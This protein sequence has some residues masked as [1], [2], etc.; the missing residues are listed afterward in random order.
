[1]TRKL[2]EEF[3][4]RF[5][6]CDGAEIYFAPGRVNLIGDHTD[7]NGGHVFP[8]ALTMGTYAVARKRADRKIRLFSMNFAKTG[9]IE[10]SLEDLV[11]GENGGWSDYPKGVFWAFFQYGYEIPYGMDL[12]LYGN[13]PNGAGLSSSA[14]LEVLVGYILNDF[15]GFR[16][17][18][19]ELAK[20][21]Q[22]AENHYNG[23]NCG[24]MDQFAVA[25]GKKQYGI[26]LNTTTLDYQYV[27]I[28]LDDVRLVI[29]CSNKKRKLTDSKYNERRS[30]CE[31]ALERIQK[32]K[33]IK[34]LGELTIDEFYEVRGAI[35][36]EVLERRAMHAVTENQRTIQAVAALQ[37]N[38]METFGALMSKSH[39]SLRD[40]YEVTGKEL[41]TLV[42]V[43]WEQEGVL[44]SRMTGA[45][46]GGCTVTLVKKDAVQAFIQKTG[47][48]YEKAIGYPADFYSVEIGDGPRKV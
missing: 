33:T 34:T 38:D 15:L 32:I 25:M 11:P 30:Q 3:Q 36:D 29:A 27:P 6:S 21:G 12:L 45:G 18:N 20:I 4:K 10:S 47:T 46:F 39:V 9:I 26:F 44:G 23:M 8:C 16:I 2:Y 14:S 24:I 19:E 17:K 28:V 13:I 35:C 42:E 5:G 48:A 37:K 22:Y 7:Y 40:N 1:M 43:A 41:D 31:T